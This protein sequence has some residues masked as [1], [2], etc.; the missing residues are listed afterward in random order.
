MK[1]FSEKGKVHSGSGLTQLSILSCWPLTPT[2][3]KKTK[4][5]APQFRPKMDRPLGN[6]RKLPIA[7]E[8]LVPPTFATL[9]ES[10]DQHQVTVSTARIDSETSVAS[11][12]PSSV[13]SLHRDLAMERLQ[14]A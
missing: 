12:Y 13:R 4:A 3:Q 8:S 14:L 11:L 7:T 9:Q 2:R 10:G 6:L 1:L 5:Y